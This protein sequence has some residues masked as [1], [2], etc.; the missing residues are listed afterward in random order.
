[1]RAAARLL[2]LLML[3]AAGS[4]VAQEKHLIDPTPPGSLNPEPLPQ[5]QNPD[6]PST[7]AKELFARKSTPFPGSPRSIG[8]YF[9]GCLAG[10]VPLP[11]TGPT[12]QVMRL[13]RNRNWGNPQLVRFIERFAEN[14]KKVGWNGLLVGDMS[15]PRGGPMLSEHRSHQI[16]LDVDIWL[17]PMPDHV[18]SREE[19]E[20]GEAADVVA[21][22]QLA[23]DPDAALFC[24]LEVIDAAEQRGLAA[25]GRA[26]DA[27]DLADRDRKIDSA[28]YMQLTKV[29][30]QPL[31]LDHWPGCHG[32][33]RHLRLRRYPLL[34][35]RSR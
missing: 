33:L 30:V 21:P 11:I 10:A 6:A 32:S 34:V 14:A 29:L 1:M 13:S 28:Q 15:Q 8:G 20:F 2:A 17:T 31:Y 27:D 3:A 24:D 16:G 18:Q 5:L 22:D 26:D 35:T 9:D 23:V 12:W 4:A 19:R 25:A 7:P